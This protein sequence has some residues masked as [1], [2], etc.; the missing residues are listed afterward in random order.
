MTIPGTI[1]YV[2]LPS[3]DLGLTKQFFSAVFNWRFVDYGP[4]YIAIENA[5]L[6]RGFYLSQPAAH[7]VSTNQ[8][9]WQ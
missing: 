5:G 1:D 7:F 9:A 2:E 8:N 6:D 3:S 4:K